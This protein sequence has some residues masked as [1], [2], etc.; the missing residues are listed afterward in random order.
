MS[1]IDVFQRVITAL[2]SAG[3]D[4]ML[5]GSFAS[6]RYSSPR[7]TQ[8]IDIVIS[9]SETQLESFIQLVEAKNYYAELDA[10]LEACRR[11][12]LF[13]IIDRDTGWKVDL[14]FRKSTGFGL[15]EFRRRQKIEVQGL[16]M[17]VAS[18]E[19]VIIAKLEWAKR[20]ASQRQI[21]DAAA[22]LQVQK[23]ALDTLYLDKWIGELQ[24]QEQWNAVSRLA[25]TAD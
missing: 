20:G 18:P 7:S 11:E 12:S 3:I 4:Y 14:I 2:E 16:Q 13:N 9:A 22:V 5:T 6:T 24:L 21:E 17:F 19:D 8:D 25:G 15:E 1:I 10:A 23:Q